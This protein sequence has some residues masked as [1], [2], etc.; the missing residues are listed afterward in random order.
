TWTA[1]SIRIGRWPRRSRRRRRPRMPGRTARRPPSWPISPG[2]CRP[3]GAPSSTA[4]SWWRGAGPRR[5]RR[6][7]PRPP[8]APPGGAPAAG[9]AGRRD[10]GRRRQVVFL[11]PG[12]GAQ[13][14]GMAR[15]LYDT[16]PVFREELD[17]C[18]ALFD[19]ALAGAGEGDAGA[20]AAE[21]LLDVLFAAA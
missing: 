19:A 10:A 20:A 13:Y 21:P 9:A 4:A 5:G 18:A 8:P 1:R 16:E 12:L 15:G 7:P 6:S 17:R 3:A 14:P 11:F 2:P